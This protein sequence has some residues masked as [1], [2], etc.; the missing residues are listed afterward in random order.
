M[1]VPPKIIS[2][3]CRGQL[4][5]PLKLDAQLNIVSLSNGKTSD[6]IGIIIFWTESWRSKLPKWS[7]LK[8]FQFFDTP[9]TPGGRTLGAFVNFGSD[10]QNWE[11]T[12]SLISKVV[13]N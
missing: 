4:E 11:S 3:H 5:C 6:I 1:N 13:I 10:I 7:S 9:G 8:C 2:P 12:S